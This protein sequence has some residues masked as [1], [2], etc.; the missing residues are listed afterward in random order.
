[1]RKRLDLLFGLYFLVFLSLSVFSFANIGLNNSVDPYIENSSNLSI[2]ENNS[3]SGE[4]KG[5]EVSNDEKL[6]F[7]KIYNVAKNKSVFLDSSKL[8]I[9]GVI[10][11]YSEDVSYSFLQIRMLDLDS[12]VVLKPNRLVFAYFEIIHSNLEDDKFSSVVLKLKIPKN[13]SVGINSSNLI[14]ARL[15]NGFWKEYPVEFYDEDYLNYYFFTQVPGLSVFAL[16]KGDSSIDSVESTVSSESNLGQIVT[17]DFVVPSVESPGVVFFKKGNFWII[18]FSVLIFILFSLYLGARSFSRKTSSKFVNSVSN[19]ADLS[20]DFDYL[21]P[22][23]TY[24]KDNLAKGYSSKM[25][26]D[27]LINSGWSRGDVYLAFERVLNE[28]KR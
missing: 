17:G 22:L 4:L 13:N 1:M 11:T 12:G 16:L 19:Y 28:G 8:P 20:C 26:G 10:F 3:I 15:E 7:Q 25:I 24:I 21:N 9:N 5:F 27:K 6:F 14:L 2:L 23:C 18:S